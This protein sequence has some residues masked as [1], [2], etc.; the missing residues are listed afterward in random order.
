MALVGTDRVTANGD[1]VNKIGT[2][3]VAILCRHFGIPFYV[4][5]PSSTFDVATPSGQQVTIE[6]RSSAEVL[7]Q[8]SLATKTRNPAFD[9]T[10]AALV[11]GII[12]E[13]GVCEP[14][15]LKQFLAD[16]R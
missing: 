16:L 15:Q 6:Q 3:N 4:A 11:S 14:V 12:T 9:V 13:H 7:G 10:P 5:S 2:L 1:V 8:H